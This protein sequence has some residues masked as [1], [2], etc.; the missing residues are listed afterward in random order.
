MTNNG[1]GVTTLGSTAGS[2][3]AATFSGVVTLNKSITVQAGNTTANDSEDDAGQTVFNDSITGTG[4]ILITGGNMVQF[5]T[6]NPGP[7]TN[8]SPNTNTD[9]MTYTGLTEVSGN[10]TFSQY[11][12]Q[13]TPLNSTVQI[14]SGS[15]VILEGVYLNNAGTFGGLSGAG[16]PRKQ[17]Q[18]AQCF[19]PERRQQQH[20][21]DF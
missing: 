19:N 7:G 13:S 16:E 3:A 17:S 10:S 21:H 4:G 1:S 5:R 18:L 20:Q 11:N 8:N 2:S 12:A 6:Q 15:T 9:L 14:D